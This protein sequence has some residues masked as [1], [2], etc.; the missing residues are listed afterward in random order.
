M[1]YIFLRI[2]KFIFSEE[3]NLKE[4]LEYQIKLKGL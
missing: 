2:H 3:A 4:E 1:D